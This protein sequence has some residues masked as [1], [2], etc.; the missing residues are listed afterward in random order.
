VPANTPLLLR[1]TTADIPVAASAEAVG[2]N[3]LVAGTGAAVA[4]EDNGKYNFILNKVDDVVGFYKAAGQTV[5]SNRAYLSLNENPFA[6]GGAANAKSVT[7]IFNG[8]TTGI[9]TV[10]APASKAAVKGTYNMQGQRVQNP[11]KG[12]Y[13]VDGKKVVIN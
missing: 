13:I 2:T 12:L 11:S 7:M 5:A 3:L 1:G 10:A 9:T 6:G 4:S 8:E